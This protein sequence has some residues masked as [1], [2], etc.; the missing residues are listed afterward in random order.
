MPA[1]GGRSKKQGSPALSLGSVLI[2]QGKIESILAE[3][4]DVFLV[5]DNDWRFAYI[6]ER[7]ATDL[8][9]RPEDLL[10]KVIWQV[11]PEYIGTDNERYLK[12]AM[13]ER[14]AVAYEVYSP[15]SKRWRAARVHPHEDGLYIYEQDITEQRTAQEELRRRHDRH[16][17]V[18]EESP[19]PIAEFD[20]DLRYV[21]VNAASVRLTGR[22]PEDFIGKSPLEAGFPEEG[23]ADWKRVVGEVFEKGRPGRAELVYESPDG[24]RYYDTRVIPLFD[25]DG[26]VTSVVSLPRA[27]TDLRRAERAA[28]AR[29]LQ[30]EAVAKLGLRL[31]DDIPARILI[32]EAVALVASTL[33]V[34]FVGF[35]ELTPG[36]EG[37]LLAAGVGWPADEIGRVRV[38]TGPVSAAGYVIERKQPLLVEDLETETRFVTYQHLHEHN[39]RS[40]VDVIVDRADRPIGVLGALSKRVRHFTEGDVSFL[41]AVANIIATAIERERHD[42]TI[43]QLSTPVLKVKERVLLVPLIGAI[44]AARAQQLTDQ[45]LQAIRT[46]RARAVV[47]DLTGVVS[48]DRYVADRLLAAIQS[49]RLLGAKAI[50]CGISGQTSRALTQTRADLSQLRTVGDLQGGIEEAERLLRTRVGRGFQSSQEPALAPTE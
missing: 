6:S 2:D 38:P 35:L 18:I 42:Q 3:M 29:A 43:R 21:Y 47:I 14:R 31:L 16:R 1:R 13:A 4:S 49:A 33:N 45:L 34:E 15:M 23:F 9:A 12:E 48:I 22:P 28:Q 50:V 26:S 27:I 10:G 19:D 5:V 24:T 40:L 25:A 44:D 11:F 20:R 41:Q 8:G 37:L 17:A 32:D 7:A 46:E 30:Q 36:E 39:I